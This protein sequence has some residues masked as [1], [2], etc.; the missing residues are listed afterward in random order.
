M[1][2]VISEKELNVLDGISNESTCK[3]LADGWNFHQ[4]LGEALFEATVV[5]AR[6]EGLHNEEIVK[7]LITNGCSLTSSYLNKKLSFY[8]FKLELKYI[9]HGLIFQEPKT[10]FTHYIEDKKL[11]EF[12]NATTGIKTYLLYFDEK[13]VYVGSSSDMK[14]RLGATTRRAPCNGISTVPS[15]TIHD[16]EAKEDTLIE[17]FTPI[18]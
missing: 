3:D 5:K 11:D 13:L 2:M 10:E 7:K 9:L 8:D 17:Y 15:N 16:A 1:Q 18:T 4:K 12:K 14:S 6:D